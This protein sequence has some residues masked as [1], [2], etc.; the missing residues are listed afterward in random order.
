MIITSLSSRLILIFGLLLLCILGASGVYTYHKALHVINNDNDAQLMSEAQLLWMMASE[1]I[2]EARGLEQID[3]DFAPPSMDAAQKKTLTN[4]TKSRAFRI[5]KDGKI[6]VQSDTAKGLQAPQLQPGFYNYK[7]WHGYAI[8]IP[9]ESIS[10][11]T[12]ETMANR[13]RVI[14]GVLDEMGEAILVLMPV[15]A[16]LIY[17]GVRYGLKDLLIMA[18]LIERRNPQDLSQLEFKPISNELQPLKQAINTLL[19]Q[20]DQM[21]KREHQFID[22]AAHELKTPLAVLKLQ[23]QLIQQAPNDAERKECIIALQ[24]GVDRTRR[25]FDQILLLSR[26]SD[27]NI[28]LQQVNLR[29]LWRMLITERAIL[30]NDKQIELSLDG[31]E[32]RINTNPEMFSLI[33]GIILDNAIKYTPFGGIIEVII[34][35]TETIV[36]DTGSG[37]PENEL[38]KVMNRFYRVK[39]DTTDGSGLGLSIAAKAAQT[40]KCSLSLS[41]KPNHQGLI[42]HLKYAQITNSY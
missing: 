18:Q 5:W 6:I 24:K 11:E 13:G 41:N 21:L 4:Y 32:V 8:S 16:L 22:D 40:I 15:A 1:E 29:N 3:L 9:N 10:I 2:E 36:S 14:L 30:A 26:L 27:K 31:E 35:K 20:L 19:E 17:L 37:I 7:E 12:W 39:G 33:G 28:E 42:A 34:G 38:D 25:V 23:S